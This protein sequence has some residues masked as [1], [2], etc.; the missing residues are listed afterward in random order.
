MI[1][2]AIFVAC[3]SST[4]AT[5]Q[6]AT[7]TLPAYYAPGDTLSVVIDLVSP[8]GT[9]AVGAEDA[10]PAGWTVSNISSSGE[11][12]AQSGKVKWGPF[13]DPSIPASVSYDVSP[14]TS[15]SSAGC[16]VGSV[17][18]DTTEVAI[19]GAACV[20]G[21]VPAASTWGLALLALLVTIGGTLILNDR[22]KADRRVH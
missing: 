22:V 15:A 17:L 14:P 5:A 21:P 11:F 1:L 8:A 6:T 3:A 2:G 4:D 19:A 18:F 20:A 10:P 13:F 9:I 12:D 16:F 7:R